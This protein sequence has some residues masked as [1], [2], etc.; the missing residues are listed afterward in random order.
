MHGNSLLTRKTDLKKKGLA[1][2]K[3]TEELIGL[4][5]KHNSKAFGKT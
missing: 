5:E 3:N 4:K 1:N 2:S